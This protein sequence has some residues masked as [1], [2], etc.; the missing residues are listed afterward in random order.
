MLVTGGLA[1]LLSILVI[2]F[3][4]K[5]SVM[6]RWI[7]AVGHVALTGI[8]IFGSDRGAALV[9]RYGFGVQEVKTS[10]EELPHES[11]P[12]ENPTEK[13]SDGHQHSH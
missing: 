4:N 10:T 9:Y 7:L 6:T 3:A 1:L 8:L 12:N 5:K 13:S 11:N 2:V